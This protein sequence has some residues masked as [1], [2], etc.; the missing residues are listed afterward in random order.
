MWVNLIEFSFLTQEN[1]H[2]KK[3]ICLGV[4]VSLDATRSSDKE[5]K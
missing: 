1:A 5:E 2:K 4:H 3:A